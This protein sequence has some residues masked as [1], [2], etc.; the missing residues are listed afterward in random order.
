VK[1]QAI[2][3]VSDRH[4]VAVCCELFGVS[5]SGYYDWLKRPSS[6]RAQREE[7]L[8]AKVVTA[9]VQNKGRYGSPRI[10]RRLRNDGEV[11]SE[12]K[13]AEIMREK[14]LSAMSRKAFRPTTTINNPSLKKSPRVYEIG[15]TEVVSENQVW[16]SDLTYIPMKGRFLYL[17]I[18]LDLYNRKVK[19]WTLEESMDAS[20]TLQTLKGAV[21]E[22]PGSLARLTFHSDQGSQYCSSTVRSSLKFLRITQSMSRKGNCYDNAFVESFFHTLKNELDIEHCESKQEV[23]AE[24]ESYISWYNCERMHSSLDYLSPE[25]FTNKQLALSA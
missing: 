2:S 17:V 13:V 21:R 14:G 20:H 25:E 22:T 16:A 12:N 3:Q 15:E 23:A 4:P 5:R 18:I 24:I 6:T 10:A 1:Y 7:A 8:E 11:V 19:S 9:F